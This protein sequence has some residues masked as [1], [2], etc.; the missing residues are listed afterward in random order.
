RPWPGAT[1][2]A[3]RGGLTRA[4]RHHPPLIPEGRRPCARAGWGRA[5]SGI[6]T[7]PSSS[8]CRAAAGAAA[9]LPEG[10]PVT[11]DSP[12]SQVTI[13]DVALYA[14]R[15]TRG[16]A[17]LPPHGCRIGRTPFVAKVE[18]RRWAA[19]QAKETS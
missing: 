4:I 12:H 5:T 10:Y 17:M 15:C 9:V 13:G 14:T 2:S 3:E 8:T 6:G 7:P 18:N 11:E 19:F 1:S 16:V